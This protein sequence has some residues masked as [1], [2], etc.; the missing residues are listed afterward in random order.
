MNFFWEAYII[1]I[2]MKLFLNLFQTLFIDENGG[3]T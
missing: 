3:K 1:D 2:D